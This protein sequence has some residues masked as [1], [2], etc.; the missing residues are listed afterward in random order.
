[1][2]DDLNF[3]LLFQIVIKFEKIL[4]YLKIIYKKNKIKKKKSEKKIETDVC[5]TK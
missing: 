1:M 3:F 5:I 2:C 4:C